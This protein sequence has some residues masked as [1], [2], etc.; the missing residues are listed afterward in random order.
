MGLVVA[1]RGLPFLID[2]GVAAW[3]WGVPPLAGSLRCLQPVAVLVSC[4][5]PPFR[6]GSPGHLRAFDGPVRAC[7]FDDGAAAMQTCSQRWSPHARACRT[8]GRT[9]MPGGTNTHFVMLARASFFRGANVS[10]V[11]GPSFSP[12]LLMRF[13]LLR[14]AMQRFAQLDYG[15]RLEWGRCFAVTRRRFLRL[16]NPSPP[17]PQASVFAA[18]RAKGVLRKTG[19]GTKS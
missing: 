7:C 15:D 6:W 14:V 12:C 2:R 10:S 3:V 18:P 11:C 8:G 5:P 16:P 17:T 13:G 4:L 19:L 9:V 1:Q